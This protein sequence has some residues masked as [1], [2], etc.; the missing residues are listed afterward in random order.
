MAVE[1]AAVFVLSLV[2]SGLPIVWHYVPI[3][4]PDIKRETD[5]GIY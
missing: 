5:S 3:C 1:I 2:S 4:W